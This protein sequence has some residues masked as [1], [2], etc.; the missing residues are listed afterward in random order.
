MSVLRVFSLYD[1]KAQAFGVPF[2]Q[3]TIGIA[4]RVITD[5]VSD[6]STTIHRHPADFT[7]YHI[8]DWSDED[9][10]FVLVI[11]PAHL[12]SGDTFVVNKER[13]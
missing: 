10:R 13:V 3:P 8:A 4:L 6:D 7:L 5:L 1:A 12:G 2:L 9:G 11:P